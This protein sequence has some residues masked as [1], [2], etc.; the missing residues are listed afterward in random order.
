MNR[1]NVL[2]V[3]GILVVVA[4]GFLFVSNMTGN[5]ITGT[6]IQG[7]VDDV[8]VENELF[9]INGIDEVDLN[10]AN[11]TEVKDGEGR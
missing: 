7:E 2:I 8:S 5:V 10:E 3:V 4:L 1:K 6:V 11:E 9:R